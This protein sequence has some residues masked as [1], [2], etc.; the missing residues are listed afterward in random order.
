MRTRGLARLSPLLVVV[1][2]A[3][4]GCNGDGVVVVNVTAAGAASVDGVTLLRVTAMLDGKTKMVDVPTGGSVDLPPA[5]SFGIAIPH[6]LT[7]QL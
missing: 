3:A 4:A 2:L 5:K 7:G 1:L 6:A